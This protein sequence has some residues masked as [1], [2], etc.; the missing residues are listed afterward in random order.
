MGGVPLHTWHH[1]C[2]YAEGDRWRG[3]TEAFQTLPR[4]ALEKIKNESIDRVSDPGGLEAVEDQPYR[5]RAFADGSRG[6]L[7]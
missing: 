4:P 6:A 5:H 1:V 7:D 3:V 2:V